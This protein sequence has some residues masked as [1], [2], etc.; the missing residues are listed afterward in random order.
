MRE[1]YEHQNVPFADGPTTE[2]EYEEED[3]EDDEVDQLLS[4]EDEGTGQAKAATSASAAGASKPRVRSQRPSVQPPIPLSRLES[5]IDSESMS[6]AVPD[7]YRIYILTLYL[8]ITVGEAMSKEALF[9]LSAA[10]VRLLPSSIV[11]AH[12]AVCLPLSVRA[13]SHSSIVRTRS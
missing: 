9:V 8:F 3:D 6:H 4:T 5:I 2:E 10:T 11:N 1:V 7:L 12:R 13:R